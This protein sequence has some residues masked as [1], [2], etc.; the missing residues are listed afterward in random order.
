MRINFD[1]ETERGILQFRQFI[2]RAADVCIEHGGSISGE[3][4][5]GQ[6]RGALLP[7]MFG[8]ELMAAFR[9]FKRLW[10][11]DNKMNPGKL[12]DAREPH[13]DLRLG[14]DYK[15]RAVDTHFRFPDDNGSLANATLRCVGV[16]AVKKTPAPCARA[17]WP[18]A[19]KS[20]RP[21]DVRIFCGSS[22]KA[23]CWKAAGRTST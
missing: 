9:E 20:I 7:K 22:Y 21:A 5:D 12:I 14:A 17:T 3:H 8:P 16:G 2:D 6:S 19:R 4:G 11:P 18:H 10:D 13:A 15:P 23:R 1:L